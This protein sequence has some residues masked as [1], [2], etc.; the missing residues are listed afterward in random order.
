MTMFEECR[1]DYKNMLEEFGM[2]ED[3]VRGVSEN[4]LDQIDMPEGAKP[5]RIMPS[6]ISGK[7]YFLMEGMQEGTFIAPSKIGDKRT[8]AGRWVNHSTEPN[9][10]A[11]YDVYGDI[12]LVSISQIDPG[13]EVTVDYRQVNQLGLNK[14]NQ[15]QQ[16]Q[17]VMLEHEQ[18]D[19]PLEHFFCK[20]LYARKMTV[21]E[22]VLFVGKVH[23]HEHICVVT[24][25]EF[26]IVT[27]KESA[28]YKAGDVIVCKPGTKRV[29]YAHEDSIWMNFHPTDLTDLDEIDAELVVDT[30]E[31]LESDGLIH[32]MLEFTGES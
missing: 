5:Y 17:D 3:F 26:S 12:F 21:K 20:D 28:R 4:M 31:A 16:L 10:I 15:I 7:G 23:K 8:P 2:D 19:C 14:R 9:A 27:E 24:K 30:F 18:V 13:C 6:A 29:G 25:G 22:G 11:E 1:S 32:K